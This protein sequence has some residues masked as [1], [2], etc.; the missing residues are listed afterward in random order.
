MGALVLAASLLAPLAALRLPAANRTRLLTAVLFCLAVCSCLCASSQAFGSVF[1]LASYSLSLHPALLHPVLLAGAVSSATAYDRPDSSLWRGA[2]AARGAL[3]GLVLG[4]PMATWLSTKLPQPVSFVAAAHL[5]AAIGIW[6]MLRHR[7]R[8]PPHG[9]VTAPANLTRLSGVVWASL[10]ATSLQY[11]AM[12]SVF[13]NSLH[14]LTDQPAIDFPSAS[15]LMV[16]FGVGG[17]AGAG[18]SARLL[19]NHPTL[20]ARFYPAILALAYVLLYI[21]AHGPDVMTTTAVLGWGAVHSSGMLITYS[22]LRAVAPGKPD[23]TTALHVCAGCVGVLTGAAIAAAFSTVFG[24][25]GFLLCGI[26]LAIFSLAAV[27][28][29]LSR[30]EV[31][32]TIVAPGSTE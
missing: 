11:A 4:L 8:N 12:F 29:Q 14:L 15:L 17:I 16:L 23:V 13:S 1:G 5:T 31:A 18:I 21:F 7:C 26:S 10:A 24:A 19:H 3:F 32:A 25:R 6:M 2:F 9:L 22:T 20:V 28:T 27:V 30:M